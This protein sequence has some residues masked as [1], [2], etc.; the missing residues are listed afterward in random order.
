MKYLIIAIAI[1]FSGCASQ[2]K[3]KVKEYVN[4]YDLK[5]RVTRVCY[6]YWDKKDCPKGTKQLDIDILPFVYGTSR[7]CLGTAE[8]KDAIYPDGMI[9]Y[10]K[11]FIK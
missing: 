9:C 4:K 11:D 10:D 7:I 5:D 6:D 8:S 2:Y 1:L 3:V